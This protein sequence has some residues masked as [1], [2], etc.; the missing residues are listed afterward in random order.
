MATTHISGSK[1]AK[2]LPELLARARAAEDIVI[3]DGIAAP[4]RL[5][6]A[7]SP[8]H[9]TPISKVIARLKA[10]EDKHEYPWIVDEDYAADIR[11]IIADRRPR[12]TSAW[13]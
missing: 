2:E 1:P 8:R 9:G 12:D 4:V 6:P 13:D 3:G 11:Q 5:A 10:I 7:S